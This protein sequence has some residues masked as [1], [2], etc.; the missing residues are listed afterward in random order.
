MGPEVTGPP[1][2]LGHQREEEKER[3]RERERER[4]KPPDV[5]PAVPKTR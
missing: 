5:K 2:F 3:E 4:R 1:R